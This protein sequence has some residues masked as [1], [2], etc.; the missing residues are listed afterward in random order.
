M[1]DQLTEEEQLE[2]LKRW[3][4]ENGKWVVTAVVLGVGGYFGWTSYD[5]QQQAKAAEGASLY[6]ELTDTLGVEGDGS[7]ADTERE[8]IAELVSQ[9]KSEHGDSAYGLQAALLSARHAV[10]SDELDTAQTE[11]KWVLDQQPE[12]ALERLVRLRL[13]RVLEARGEAEAALA[14]LEAGTPGETLAAAWAEVRGD[15]LNEQGDV[16]GA[17]RAYETAMQ[18]LGEQEGNR[19]QVLQMKLDNL[20]PAGANPADEENA[21]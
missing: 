9:L 11:L 7:L 17:V 19:R 13:A 20:Q 14:Q 10:E 18:S 1:N 8:E 4:K 3:W 6:T 15:I 16:E 2:A 21:S 5:A 12:P